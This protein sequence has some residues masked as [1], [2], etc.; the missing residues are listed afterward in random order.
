MMKTFVSILALASTTMAFANEETSEYTKTWRSESATGL[1]ATIEIPLKGFLTKIPM[2]VRFC[3]ET[4][5]DI[6][7]VLVNDRLLSSP[8]IGKMVDGC[9][10]LNW[11]VFENSGATKLTL[12]TRDSERYQFSIKVDAFLRYGDFPM[13]MLRTDHNRMVVLNLDKE[14]SQA[15]GLVC[16][17]GE[18]LVAVRSR[19]Y[20]SNDPWTLVDVHPA[21]AICSRINS[22]PWTHTYWDTRFVLDSGEE[23]TFIH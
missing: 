6:S 18:K 19:P 23:I 4:N 21:S 12:V 14:G 11:L 10:G 8:H 20:G 16:S 22:F 15:G 7:D 1:G 3:N 5:S 13:F 2:A 17:N 9:Q